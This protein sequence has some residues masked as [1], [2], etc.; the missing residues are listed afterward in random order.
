MTTSAFRVSAF[1]F[2]LRIPQAVRLSTAGALSFMLCPSADRTRPGRERA[3]AKS[4]FCPS[5][6][7]SLYRHLQH[8]GR[9][10]TRV[11]LAPAAPPLRWPGR[12]NGSL[13][14]AHKVRLATISGEHGECYTDFKSEAWRMEMYAFNS[15]NLRLE[16][17]QR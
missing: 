12:T 9:R 13:A 6:S 14:A 7:L 5:L 15:F 10:T 2:G 3:R 1:G 4:G 11:S 17:K 8:H 16:P